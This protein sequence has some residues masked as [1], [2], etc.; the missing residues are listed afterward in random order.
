[1]SQRLASLRAALRPNLIPILLLATL[2]VAAA[3]RFYAL[4][5]DRGHF[6]HPDERAKIGRAHV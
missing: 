6:F 5:W 4:D 2:L 1:M 3:L